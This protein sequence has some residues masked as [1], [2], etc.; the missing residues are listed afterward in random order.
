M[1]SN[2]NGERFPWQVSTNNGG[3]MELISSGNAFPHLSAISNE[4]NTPKVF[5]C[6]KDLPSRTRVATWDQFANDTNVSY[7]VG[8]DASEIYPQS[9]LTGDRN[10]STST[11]LLSGL[12]LVMSNAPM[13]WVAGL[14]AP[15]GNIGLADGS[16][17]QITAASVQAQRAMDTNLAAR[18]VF[19]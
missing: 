5:V 17:A 18:F 6:T 4:V 14:H 15:V 1:W 12:V 13:T 10:L 9:M 2:D 11:K 16:A 8:L 7:F 3:T 19:P